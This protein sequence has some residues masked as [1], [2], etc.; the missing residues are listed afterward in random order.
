MKMALKPTPLSVAADHCYRCGCAAG[1]EFTSLIREMSFPV[2]QKLA[3][4]TADGIHEQI[5]VAIAIQIRE[6]RAGRKLLLARDTGLRG[7]VLKSPSA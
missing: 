5:Q 4:A 6:D 3:R 7:Y 1:K 2:V